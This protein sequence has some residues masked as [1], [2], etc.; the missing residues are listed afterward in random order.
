MP[1]DKSSESQEETN[2]THLQEQQQVA[3]EKYEKLHRVEVP[4]VELSL[5]EQIS[6]CFGFFIGV[7]DAHELHLQSLLL[8]FYRDDVRELSTDQCQ[9]TA[10][11]FR[12]V[13]SVTSVVDIARLFPGTNMP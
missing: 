7:L 11:D 3:Q 1:Q 10:L 5:C 8:E 9:A 4:V 12:S 13:H 2:D 6:R